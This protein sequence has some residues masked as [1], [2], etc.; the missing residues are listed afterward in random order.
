[1]CSVVQRQ[2]YGEGFR[3]LSQYVSVHPQPASVHRITDYV[4]FYTDLGASYMLGG[5]QQASR[6]SGMEGLDYVFLIIDFSR[7]YIRHRRFASVHYC[8]NCMFTYCEP[9]PPLSI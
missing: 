1:M 5:R 3:W 9:V 4:F 8:S 2:G 7:Y 6:R